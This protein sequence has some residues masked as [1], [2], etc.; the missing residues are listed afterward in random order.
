MTPLTLPG[1]GRLYTA[2]Q[3]TVAVL[4]QDRN[5]RQLTDSKI[6][7]TPLSESYVTLKLSEIQKRCSELMQEPEGL[8][9]LRLEESESRPDS[10]DP[11]NRS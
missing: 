6:M 1:I 3:G 7:D 11:Y 8:I 2:A 9:E 10:G 5:L 4:R